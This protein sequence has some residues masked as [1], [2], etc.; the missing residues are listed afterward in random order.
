MDNQI[1]HFILHIS[2]LYAYYIRCKKLSITANGYIWIIRY[3]QLYSHSIRRF[4]LQDHSIKST[5]RE[6][7]NWIWM[8][9]T[10]KSALI[11]KVRNTIAFGQ[12][13]D[14]IAIRRAVISKPQ[15]TPLSYPLMENRGWP[16]AYP[17]LDVLYRMYGTSLLS[18]TR[19]LQ[20]L[21][22]YTQSQS[23]RNGNNKWKTTNDWAKY[24]IN[25][26]LVISIRRR[27]IYHIASQVHPFTR[28][29][30]TYTYTLQWLIS[31]PIIILIF[32][33]N[34]QF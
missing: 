23:R 29:H 27:R 22:F 33:I 11:I 19:N 5:S 20:A 24:K 30:T 7:L 34:S 26:N 31:R 32:S 21:Y 28:T 6:A 8:L 17:F 25:V 1:T 16:W 9:L 12:L 15:T 10:H 13:G 14:E 4:F 2:T 18:F 3:D